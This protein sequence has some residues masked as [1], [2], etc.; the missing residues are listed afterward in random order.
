[1]AKKWKEVGGFNQDAT[2]IDI[3]A[4]VGD[5]TEGLYKGSTAHVGDNDST[6]H[7]VEVDGVLCSFWG[8]KVLDERLKNVPV[9]SEIKIEYKGT[10]KSK[11]PGRRGYHDFKI[12]MAEDDG[13]P[14]APKAPR[15][16]TPVKKAVSSNETAEEGEDD[17][18]PF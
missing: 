9:D 4:Q 3:K 17:D 11:T 7:Y 1:M 12:E 10:V 15:R 6:I 5:V 14:E 8:S 2:Q 16:V 13:E 18:V